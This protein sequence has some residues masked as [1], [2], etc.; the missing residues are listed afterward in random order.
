MARSLHWRSL[1]NLAVQL[2]VLTAL[3]AA[4]LFV[5]TPQVS[6][7]SMAP[8]IASGEYVLVDTFAYRFAT[9]KRGDI[10]AFRTDGDARGV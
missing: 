6:G 9:P 5:R 2:A 3:V 4:I 8:H 1:A 10:V 7:L